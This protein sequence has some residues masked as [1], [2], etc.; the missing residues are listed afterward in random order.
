MDDDRPADEKLALQQIAYLRRLWHFHQ[1]GTMQR[2]YKIVMGVAGSIVLLLFAASIFGFVNEWPSL[3]LWILGLFA[4]IFEMA[5]VQVLTG[6]K[7]WKIM[8]RAAK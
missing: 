2:R 8:E 5:L 4:G 6:K 3:A 7:R 1:P